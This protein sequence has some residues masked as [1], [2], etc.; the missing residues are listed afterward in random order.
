MRGSHRRGLRSRI[1]Q[2]MVREVRAFNPDSYRSTSAVAVTK[3][4]ASEPLRDKI[5]G[6]EGLRGQA[7]NEGN[8][9]RILAPVQ[10]GLD[11]LRTPICREFR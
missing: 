3:S 4:C 8:P 6:L 1:G 9:T 7:E 10:V 11:V 2:G 5:S